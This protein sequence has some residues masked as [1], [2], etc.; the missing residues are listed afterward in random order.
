MDGMNE[1]RQIYTEQIDL[2]LCESQI[3]IFVFFFTV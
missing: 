1:Q 2:I 3:L